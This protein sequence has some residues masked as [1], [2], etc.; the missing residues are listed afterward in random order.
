MVPQA[1]HP[2]EPAHFA[3]ACDWQLSNITKTLNPTPLLLPSGLKHTRHCCSLMASSIAGLL[4]R[5]LTIGQ[6]SSRAQAGVMCWCW[7]AGLTMAEVHRDVLRWD[8]FSVIG[9]GAM[10]AGL[11]EAARVPTRFQDLRQ[12]TSVFRTL[13]LEELRAHMQQV[14][15]ATFCLERLVCARARYMVRGADF[16]HFAST[17]KAQRSHYKNVMRDLYATPAVQGITC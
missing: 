12:Y 10:R 8:Y 9:G 1:A 14:L 4:V 2:P 13:L 16:C 5:L 15:L 3:A 11:A 6:L 7:Q 17:L